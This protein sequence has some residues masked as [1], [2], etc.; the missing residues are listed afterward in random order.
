M[1]GAKQ[2]RHQWRHSPIG[3]EPKRMYRVASYL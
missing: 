1:H 3:R 2:L